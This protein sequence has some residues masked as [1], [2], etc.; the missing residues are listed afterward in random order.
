MAIGWKGWGRRPAR[1]ADI[2]LE[3][4]TC[5]VLATLNREA[6]A[7]GDVGIGRPDG[8]A[9]ILVAEYLDRDG[10]DG[11]PL[12]VSEKARCR[13]SSQVGRTLVPS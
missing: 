13:G 5:V 2:V 1:E 9:V 10:Q 12:R 7:V 11:L 3:K 4:V 8:K 6:E